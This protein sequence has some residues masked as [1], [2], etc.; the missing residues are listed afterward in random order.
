REPPPFPTRR[1]SDLW[2][3]GRP[4][5]SRRHSSPYHPGGGAW[6]PPES[7]LLRLLLGLA[8]D[9]TGLPGLGVT[10]VDEGEPLGALAGALVEERGAAGVHRALGAAEDRKSTR[11]N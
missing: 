8:V 5:G 6:L 1:S 10:L 11:L 7:G 4:E 2:D 9:L 3:R